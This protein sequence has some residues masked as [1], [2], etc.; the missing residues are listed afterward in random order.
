MATNFPTSVDALTNPVSNDSLNSPSHSAQHANANDAIEAVEDYLLNGAGKTGLILL[1][2]STFTGSATVNFTDVLS[3]TYSHYRIV[4]NW[5]GNSNNDAYMRFRE[6]TTDKATDYYVSAA[7]GNNN[8]TV[9]AYAG[10]PATFIYIRQHNTGTGTRS[11][12]TLDI[13]RPSATNGIVVGT[14]WN[15]LNLNTASIGGHNTSMTNFTGFS[16]LPAAGTITGEVRLYA[17]K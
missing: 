13:I 11:A 2:S 12:G 9:S 1:S 14:I 17:Y 10:A 3:S 8:A 16:I 15:A 5:F 6:S 7:I 4:F